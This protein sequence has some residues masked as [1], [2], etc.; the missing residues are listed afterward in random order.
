MGALFRLMRYLRGDLPGTA[1]AFVCMLAATAATLVQPGLVETAVDRGL[2]EGNMAAVLTGAAGILAFA[3]ASG[4][5]QFGGLILLVRA[6][7]G[8]AFRLRNSLFA[9]VMGLS[10]ADFDRL[11]TGEIIVRINSDVNT[12]RVFVRMGLLMVVQSILML[13]GAILLMWNSNAGLARIMT[14]VLPGTLVLFVVFAALIRPV[15]LR[16]R[17]RIDRMN[18]VLQ[19][20]LA[21]AKVVRA[22]ARQDTERDRFDEK[23]RAVY[24]LS[25]KVGYAVSL[26][27]PLL[28]LLGQLAIVATV[29][30]GGLD[31]IALATGVVENAA[32]APTLGELLAFTNYAILALWP[33]MALG[34]VLQFISVASASATRIEDLL[35]EKSALGPGGT[36]GGKALDGEIAL[37]GVR[38]SYGGEAAVIDGVDLHVPSGTT[39]GIIGP[40]GSGKS[41]LVALI[42]RFYDAD[43]GSIRVDGVDVREYD[44]PELRRRVCVVLQESVLLSGT[45]RQNIAFVEGGRFSLE[46]VTEAACAGDI[47]DEKTEGFDHVV[48]ERGVGL[49]GGQRQRIAIARALYADPD[50]LILDD[51]SSALD[52]VTERTLVANLRRLM[53]GR[54]LVLV[55]QRVNTV[56]QADRI[57]VVDDGRIVAEGAHDHLLTDSPLYREIWESQRRELRV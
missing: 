34:M 56:M 28:F 12:I 16:L 32:E 49:S 15:V 3:V 17:A 25:V 50:V 42:P 13:G 10:F 2:V 43:E 5:L 20:N 24:D 22:F 45:I 8:L 44:L 33:I 52:A 29:Y 23:N 47:I 35:A 26:L 57:V 54:T 1:L 21:G 11:R 6:S 40:T 30:F 4:A 14:L 51:A 36:R 7:Q 55:S 41:S 53:A 31:I 48:G 39:L 38:F 46:E 19:E 9:K 18:N 27:Y 37:E